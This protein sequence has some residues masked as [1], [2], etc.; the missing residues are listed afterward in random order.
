[1][2]QAAITDGVPGL[3]E[4]STVLEQWLDCVHQGGAVWE[5][6]EK[7]RAYLLDLLQGGG[8]K[9]HTDYID[10][11]YKALPAVSSPRGGSW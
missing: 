10:L 5:L 6:P 2:S 3:H 11:I 9:L 7:A 8:I 4:A 1:L